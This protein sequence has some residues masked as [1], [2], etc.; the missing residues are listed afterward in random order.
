MTP[1]LALCFSALPACGSD[2]R[3]GAAG[4]GSLGAAA[5]SGAAGFVGSGGAATAGAG[6]STA[7]TSSGGAAVVGSGGLASGGVPGVV[8]S[9]GSGV[10]GSGGTLAGGGATGASGATSSG[11]VAGASGA[12]TAGGG[13]GG[14]GGAAC[15]KTVM[16]SMDCS[17]PLAP[18]DQRSCMAG[19]R[20][21]YIY[22]PK[23][24]DPC[25]P[26]ALVVDAH[27][28]TQTAESQLF[29][30]PPFCTGANTCWSGPGSGWRLEAEMPGGGFILVTPSS[31]TS[32][33]TWDATTD[34]PVMM[35]MIQAVQKLADIDPKKIYF[36]GISNGAALSY[37]TA[38][39]NPGV[40]A[41][42]S[43][44]SGG[45]L[46]GSQCNGLMKPLS[47]IQFDDMPDFAFM[48]SQSTV[49]AMAKTDNCK[50]GPKDWKT[51][52]ST[53]TDLVCRTNPDDNAAMLVPCNTITPPIQPTKCQIWDQCDG[54][55]QVVF[56][57]V[58][59]GTMHGAANAALD[60]HIIYEN[61]S[62]L[63]TPSVAWRFFKSL[64]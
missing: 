27:G 3:S 26:A 10:T 52:D 51:I 57:Q 2:T 58:A 44:N 56:C 43:P 31:A 48:D 5:A 14:S 23:N 4:T 64:W 47:D 19:G 63:N 36:T 37:W 13:Q 61:A 15:T 50:E 62:N 40:F 20:Q 25:E 22:V 45:V 6:G 8:G 33:N 7:A 28:A 17:A 32:S 35:Q 30:K 9:G 54:G 39:A 34:P 11:G 60:G 38:C 41:G 49:T 16:S 12:G 59:P 53:T 21:Y 1:A 55:T 24:Y 29:G 46:G 42:I 18:G